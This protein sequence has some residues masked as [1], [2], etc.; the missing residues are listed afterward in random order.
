MTARTV[1]SFARS[2]K[3][4]LV[5]LDRSPVGFE[6]DSARVDL[7][8]IAGDSLVDRGRSMLTLLTKREPV[9]SGLAAAF[10]R[11]P[12][13][14]PS[15]LYFMIRAAAADAVEWEQI[16][17]PPHGFCALD[18]RWPVGRIAAVTQQIKA[19]SF[20]PPLRIV[21]V[22]SAAG[23]EGQPQ[24]HALVKAVADSPIPASLHVLSGDEEL[25]EEAKASKA[26][27]AT[28]A[29]TA[30]DLCRQIS[31]ARPHVLHLL[32]HGGTVAG[33]K[34]L[35]FATVADVDAERHDL[36][37][38]RMS[39]ADLVNAL[40]AA[41]PW[42]V[43]LGGCETAATDVVTGRAMAHD[44]VSA[45]VTAAIGMRRR[46]DRHEADLFCAALYPELLATVHDAVVSASGAG[47]ARE[48]I[49]DWAA[50]L[51]NPR[52]VMSGADPSTGDAWL[53][54]VLYAQNEDMRVLLPS[55]QLA[56]DTYAQLQGER[57]A[58]LSY[59]ASVD[60]ASADPKV[61]DEVHQRVAEVEQRLA[62]AGVSM[63][64]PQP[65]G[66]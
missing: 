7:T 48:V 60:P 30:P 46:V 15:P 3:S 50:A 40:D 29:G 6:P 44:I 32:C 1:V 18:A 57:N 9:K 47:A 16:Y 56:P 63:P 19:K 28:I 58:Y 10:A 49:I 25:V 45:G 2:G 66:I 61:L 65:S 52:K 51:T 27:A 14:T 34:T 43:V 41:D 5:T 39:S 55:A 54:P 59:L 36:G 8:K 20:D 13:S 21:A 64:P 17:L 35:A 23:Q 4:I 11:P 31:A 53:D 38:V 42:L 24:L 62:L 33:V 26:T 22:L 37:S 12:G